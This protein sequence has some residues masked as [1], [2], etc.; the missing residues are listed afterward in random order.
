MSIKENKVTLIDE[1]QKLKNIDSITFG[2]VNQAE[3]TKIIDK[4]QVTWTIDLG[5]D[6]F[7]V[8]LANLLNDLRF[9]NE[10]SASKVVSQ[11]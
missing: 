2:L 5:S 3:I 10:T 11:I 7:Q 8:N 6:S 9:N 1:I 4:C